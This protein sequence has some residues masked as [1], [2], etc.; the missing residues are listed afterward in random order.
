MK[1]RLINWLN[2]A[3]TLNLFFVLFSFVWFASA[4]VGRAAN[5]NLGFDLWYSL[6]E[7]LFMPAIGILMAGAIISGII[8]WVSNRFFAKG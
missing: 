3:L 6:W 4:L 7:P 5:I 1:D 8:G 2:T